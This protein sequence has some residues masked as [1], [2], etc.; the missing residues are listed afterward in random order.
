M[1]TTYWTFL[2]ATL[3]ISGLP[4]LS[5]FY[6]KEGILVQALAF[7]RYREDFVSWLPFAFGVVTAGMTA[8]Y[9]FRLFFSV[10]HGEPRNRHAHEHAHESPWT[11]TVPLRT[12][13]ILSLVA[14]GVLF[15][16]FDS[17]WFQNR[18]S[19]E[20]LLRPDSLA[21]LERFEALAEEGHYVVLGLSVGMFVVG[22][23]LASL[24]F[25]PRGLFYGRQ[26]IREGTF[27]GFLHECV[28]N[29]WYVDALLTWVAERAIHVGH[30]AAGAFDKFVIDG[31][32]NFWGVVCRFLTVVAGTL[33]FRGVDGLVRGIGH[34]NLRL[35]LLARR[36]Q[37]G[38]LQE[39][40]Y[41]S[42]FIVTGLFMISILI[43]VTLRN[44]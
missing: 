24:F 1:P 20:I 3:A 17:H 2:V 33:D 6:S 28:W 18:V 9:M 22:V 41:A 25:L 4:F 23:G 12:L 26:V 44:A 14:G 31:A 27:L 13:A 5:G 34:V 35:G 37:S 38:L 42:I 40:V 7:A 16:G 29:L 36:L 8:F 10:F 43:I 21:P 30:V 39:Y 32:V 11:M 15:T 19:S